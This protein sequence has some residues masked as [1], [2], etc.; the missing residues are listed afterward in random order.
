MTQRNDPPC[1]DLD[2]EAALLGALLSGVLDEEDVFRRLS[3][4]DFW[5]DL[6]TRVFRTMRELH[7]ARLAIGTMEVVLRLGAQ[8]SAARD[9]ESLEGATSS[10]GMRVTELVGHVADL[11]RRRRVSERLAKAQVALHAG[12]VDEARDLVEK[13]R[14]EWVGPNRLRRLGTMIDDAAA[15]MVRRHARAELPLATPWPDVNG[16][17]GGGL[18]P[19][20]HMLVSG[21]G[22]GKSTWSLQLALAAAEAGTPVAYVGLELDDLQLVLRLAAEKARVRWSELY[23]GRASDDSIGRAAEAMGALERLPLYL[24]PGDP[25]G[26]APSRLREVAEAI[27]REHP[28]PSGP[29]SLPMLLVLDFLQ[30]VGDETDAT[31]RRERL[32][33]RERI[34]RAAYVGRQI[35]RE[36]GV[37]VLMVSSTAR[38]R[39]GVVSGDVSK[40]GMGLDWNG[41]GGA[42]RRFIARP[43]ELVGLGKESGEI[44]YAADSVTVAIALS[45]APRTEAGALVALASPKVRTGPPGW[46][47]LRFDGH[48]FTACDDGGEAAC[49]ALRSSTKGDGE[50][51]GASM[52]AP[53]RRNVTAAA[54]GKGGRDAKDTDVV[55]TPAQ[56]SL[57]GPEMDGEGL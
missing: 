55:M 11:G 7:E 16:Q 2:A 41:P 21:T 44:E 53:K 5:L 3:P 6:H 51:A 40:A 19:G 10:S 49:A 8:G 48:R 38:E 56:A 45:G 9:V 23:T 57:L 22:A 1:T 31:G 12:E 27:R 46:C 20:L 33:L 37:V 24:E 43:D 13:A 4:A 29:G 26:W 50:G 18:W 47:A 15:R 30:L 25:L 39:Y 52:P 36:L 17:M 32:E 35:A 28:E 34:G 54:A 42:V 14:G